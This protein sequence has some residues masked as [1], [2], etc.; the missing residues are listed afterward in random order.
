M[1][2]NGVFK[3]GA[4]SLIIQAVHIC[5]VFPNALSA[6]AAGTYREYIYLTGG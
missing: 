1:M 6:A 4:Y 5:Y 2:T 3:A